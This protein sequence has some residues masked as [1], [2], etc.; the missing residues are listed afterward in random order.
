MIQTRFFKYEETAQL[1][2][3]LKGAHLYHTEAVPAI[4]TKES[5]VL[6]IYQEDPAHLEPFIAAETY[7]V[8]ARKLRENLLEYESD[9]R[10]WTWRRERKAARVAELEKDIQ[11]LQ[12]LIDK[13]GTDKVNREKRKGFE[14]KQREARQELEGSGGKDVGA[15]QQLENIDEQLKS[16]DKKTEDTK[17]DMLIALA[18][19]K[20]IEDEKFEVNPTE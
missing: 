6:V 9:R 2:E 17:R 20:E 13:C 3:F 10:Q 18:F 4:Q 16:L 12:D 14:Q 1:N 19:A 11:D 5:G 15:R 7:R 8:A